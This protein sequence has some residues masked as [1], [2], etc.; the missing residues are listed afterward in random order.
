MKAII[1]LALPALLALS[2]LLNTGYANANGLND[3]H[4]WY[5][6]QSNVSGLPDG[7]NYLTV[8]I[9][10]WSDGSVEFIVDVIDGALSITNPDN[11]GIQAF[12][13]NTDLILESANFE[14]LPT[15][16][17]GFE[18]N[19][20][21]DGFGMFDVRLNDGGDRVDPLIFSIVDVEN[22]TWENYFFP[23]NKNSWFAVHVA[24]IETFTHVVTPDGM[25]P[26]SSFGEC[27]ADS[28]QEAGY[29]CMSLTSAWFAG[30]TTGPGGEP[31]PPSEVP[32]PAALWLF[33][34]GLIG[35][36][37]LAR[38]KKS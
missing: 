23:G 2:M 4:S 33:G 1:R 15:D 24:N 8:T 26:D 31:I 7:T 3:T 32:V 11:F 6:D 19:K 18:A 14:G 30:G 16:K 25:D 37:G 10:E 35:L 20:N 38:R 27:S 28:I 36:A 13:F 22:D 34:S 9:N 12:T 21:G 5:L 17:W 29:S